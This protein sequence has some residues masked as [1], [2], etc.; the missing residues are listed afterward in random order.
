M[1]TG[2]LVGARAAQ[3]GIAPFFRRS[4]ISRP[5]KGEKRAREAEGSDRLG[6]VIDALDEENAPILVNETT[7][8]CNDGDAPID[9]E[10]GN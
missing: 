7:L 2:P 8:M 5:V 6:Q 3:W 10:G 1:A 9:W 4:M